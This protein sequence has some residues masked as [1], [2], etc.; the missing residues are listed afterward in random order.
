MADPW[1][2]RFRDF[3]PSPPIGTGG[4]RR[5]DSR[6]PFNTGGRAGADRLGV[7]HGPASGRR[8]PVFGLG[9][10]LGRIFRPCQSSKPGWPPGPEPGVEGYIETLGS[11]GP[12]PAPSGREFSRGGAASVGGPNRWV[13]RPCQLLPT[14]HGSLSRCTVMI[15]GSNARRRRS[16]CSECRTS[17]CEELV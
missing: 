14:G 9:P 4:C 2:N 17:V 3:R 12:L 7:P 13:F 16:H 8:P 15:S 10:L 1:G 11:P 5:P 6:H